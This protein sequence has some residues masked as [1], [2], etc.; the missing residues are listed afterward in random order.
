MDFKLI[1]TDRALGD[2]EK[3][4]RYYVEEEQS[5]EAAA[6]VGTA[7]VERV[8]I[9]KT[10]PDIGPKYPKRDGVHREVLCYR[11]RIFYRVD[12]EAR[13]VYVARV[14]EGSQDP[15]KLEL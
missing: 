10:F 12:R 13:V 4:V 5:R 15:E 8:E 1:W 2:L 3:I 6:K 14:W 11:Y 7:I 9:L